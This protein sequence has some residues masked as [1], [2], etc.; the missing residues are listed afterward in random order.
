VCFRGRAGYDE[1]PDYKK[2]KDAKGYT[3]LCYSCGKSSLDGRQIIQCD[4]CVHSWHLDCLDPPLSNP[5]A[6]TIDNKK[7]YD[8]MCPLHV[9]HELRKVDVSLLVPRRKVHLRRRKDGK[10]MDTHLNRG[11]VNTGI[12]DVANDES[13]DS[14]SEFYENEN[15]DEGVVYKLPSKS[16]KLDFIDKVKTYV[17]SHPIPRDVPAC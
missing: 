10:V 6:R 16:I 4:Y 7:L 9:D 8:W 13:D 5:P 3:V 15:E 2:L 11:F 14:E 12:I 17:Q 1:V